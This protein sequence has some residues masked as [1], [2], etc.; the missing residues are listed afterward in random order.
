[1]LRLLGA[2]LI[3]KRLFV[4]ELVTLGFLTLNQVALEPLMPEL[5]AL[6]LLTLKIGTLKLLVIQEGLFLGDE[7]VLCEG[8]V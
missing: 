2:Q 3:H 4:I 5:G 6:E 1:M 7:P 8:L